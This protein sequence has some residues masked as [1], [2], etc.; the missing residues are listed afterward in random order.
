MSTVLQALLVSM[1]SAGLCLSP[2][3]YAPIPTPAEAAE[4]FE[5]LDPSAAQS[6][7]ADAWVEAQ[8][9]GMSTEE[10]VGQLFVARVHSDASQGSLADAEQLV[11]EQHIGGLCFF[12]GTPEAQVAWT[13]Q[14]Q[15]ASAK[16]PLLV[17]MDAEWGVAMRFGEQFRRLPYAMT[18]G[19]ANN[20]E[21]TR[22]IGRETG[23]QLRRLGVHVSFAPVA[24][25]NSNPANP[26]IGRRSFGEDPN[27]VGQL[28]MAYARGLSDGG[29][30]AVVKHYPGHG[31]T[32]VDS[33]VD[34]PIVRK[35][36]AALDTLE[37]VPFRMLAQ[38]GV[39]GI[40]TGHLAV[41]AVDSR[42]N[43]PASLSAAITGEVLRKRW[44]YEGLIVTDGLDMAGITKHFSP[45]QAALEALQAGNDLL[46]IPK[47][48]PAGIGAIVQALKD[49][50][51]KPEVV[52]AAVRRI[53]RAKYAAG[54]ANYTPS[55]E[56]GA[57]AEVNLPKVDELSEQLYRAAV[58]VVRD[59]TV[60]LPL[61]N[62]VG[63]RAAVVSLGQGGMSDFQR[64]VARYMP[65]SQLM[66]P[67]KLEEA[68][69]TEWQRSL[70]AYDVVF[71]GLHDL[72]FDAK[73]GYGLKEEH[74]TLLRGLGAKTRVV[75][76][77]FGTPYLL[78]NLE[79][80][81]NVVLAYEDRP[82]AQKAAAE[83]I[84]GAT[85]LFG[86]LPVS[87]GTGLPR[88]LGKQSG[89]LARLLYSDV[90]RAGFGE[91]GLQ[92]VD[93]I[94]AS[95]IAAHATPGGVL[96]A[97]RN[98]EVGYL[99]AYG[100]FTYD[101]GSLPVDAS[102][103][104]DLAS[105]T[106]VAAT[107]LAIMR[108][109]EQGLISVY[110]TIGQHLPMLVNTNKAPLKIYDILAHQARLE[111]WIPFFEQTVTSTGGVKQHLPGIYTSS[112]KAGYSIPVTEK[113]FI[114]DAWRDTIWRQIGA[115]ALL[116]G[117]GYKYSDLGFYIMAEIVR[118]KT[119]MELDAYVEREF[120]KPLGLS[121]M[122]FRPMQRLS[123]QQVAPTEDD[124]YWRFGRVQGYVHDMG[125]A[126]LGGVSGH[127]GLFS[128]VN[129]LAVIGQLMLNDGYYGGQRY[130]K[131]ET[132]RLFTT[133][134]ASSTRR[135]L[136]W[137][138]AELSSR[139]ASN[140]SE[141]ASAKTFGH[142]GFTG[143]CM[144]ADPE[145]GVLFVWLTNRTYP[146]MSQN[147]FNSDRYRPRLQS[148]LLEGLEK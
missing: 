49:K 124:T 19:A 105:V 138:M 51:L 97:A 127:A 37:L 2:S 14:L 98:G 77:A 90:G 64:S 78:P 43:R 80:F 33:H 25:L 34:V 70:S 36:M 57:S 15:A 122:G 5:P 91:S 115:S 145:T 20:P 17:S 117:R 42:S 56:A 132:V 125:A 41:P 10:R 29:V 61:A 116:P 50:K 86:T 119:G 40:M 74:L 126:M 111:A 60:E 141:L 144:W 52:D 12:Q 81:D 83:V 133:R 39:A 24:D 31:D 27:R 128:S 23:R 54:L 4:R 46:L 131:P 135:G 100:K 139:G 120:Y 88:G 63:I 136:G 26:V 1:L 44:K 7:Q 104:Y 147:K 8:L 69:V 62:L 95:A 11:R 32:E 82:L 134:H 87:A 112:S 129:D 109:H 13:N 30:L 118:E 102:T 96:L 59:Q 110:D 143:T 93:G 67:L 108:L 101:A 72:N 121:T 73:K 45:A 18:I 140:M 58:T 106:K 22:A 137:D 75:V 146:R 55:I 114:A 92:Q 35:S 53:L 107:T 68:A 47:D 94:V 130:F 21:L 3:M 103:V 28:A 85:P 38:D 66:V 16:T 71:A 48:I 123:T 84:F 142:L 148:A 89:S 9:T 65:V 99:K 79:G 76:V 6:P 113:L